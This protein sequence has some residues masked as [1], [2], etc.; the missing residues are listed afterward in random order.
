MPSLLIVGLPSFCFSLR[1]LELPA[2]AV[3]VA[4]EK[5]FELRGF[6]FDA[7]KEE[8]RPPRIVRVAAI[9]NKVS[10]V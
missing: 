2:S 1:T 8:I 10:N 7:A 6:A 9:Q 4:A 5:D 3:S